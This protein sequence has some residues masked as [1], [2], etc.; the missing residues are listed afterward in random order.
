MAPLPHFVDVRGCN[1]MT[2]EMPCCAMGRK[3]P[4]AFPVEYADDLDPRRR[5]LPGSLF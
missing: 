5:G 2:S 3:E 1:P 4:D